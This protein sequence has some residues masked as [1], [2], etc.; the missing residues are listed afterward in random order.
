MTTQKTKDAL[1]EQIHDASRQLFLSVRI[2]KVCR[3]KG[4]SRQLEFVPERMEEE[5]ILREENRKKRRIKRAGFPTYRT[6]EG[7]DYRCSKFPSAFSR[8]GLET[9][10]FIKDKVNLVLYESV[11]ISKTHITITAGVKACNMGWDTGQNSIR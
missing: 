11:G 5:L 8:Q 9:I 7:Y 6:F 10:D 4:G 2:S 3:E 1:C